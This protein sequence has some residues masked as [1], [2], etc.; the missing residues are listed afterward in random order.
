MV[1]LTGINRLKGG[2]N[3]GD[4]IRIELGRIIRKGIVSG[5]VRG[6]WTELGR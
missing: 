6:I 1:K 5:I 2:G 3:I 4:W